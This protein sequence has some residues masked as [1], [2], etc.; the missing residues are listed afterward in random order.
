MDLSQ[1]GNGFGA[2][3]KGNGEWNPAV[4]KVDQYL[5][6]ALS[7]RSFGKWTISRVE[8]RRLEW[9]LFLFFESWS[10]SQILR[11]W[12][13]S[14][15][16]HEYLI[17][18]IVESKELSGSTFPLPFL[19]RPSYPHLTLLYQKQKFSLGIPDFF[20]PQ[21]FL[22]DNIDKYL[23]EF[24]SYVN[25]DNLTPIH[26][27]SH[28]F[29]SPI[30]SGSLHSRH[31]FRRGRHPQFLNNIPPPLLIVITSYLHH[32]NPSIKT[33]TTSQSIIIPSF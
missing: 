7:A 33:R 15:P 2:R 22:I 10:C 9:S 12:I 30:P 27:T 32:R 13:L 21:P 1:G 19:S 14:S 18:Q 3:G 17:D 16:G 25:L 11:Q 24:T 26:T 5:L 4:R 20:F 8:I 23:A 6:T 31:S 29:F 28:S